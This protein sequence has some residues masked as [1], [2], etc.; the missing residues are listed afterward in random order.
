MQSY[1]FMT[2]V[3]FFSKT[4]YFSSFAPFRSHSPVRY[5]YNVQASMIPIYYRTWWN[6]KISLT[7]LFIRSKNSSFSWSKF[8]IL[9]F[10]QAVEPRRFTKFILFRS[11]LAQVLEMSIEPPF[12]ANRVLSFPIIIPF[13]TAIV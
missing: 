13:A 5:R 12:S 2:C 8:S 10:L 6:F 7:V 11:D 4:T 1:F 9:S 3:T